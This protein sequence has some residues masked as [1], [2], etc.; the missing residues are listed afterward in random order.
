V[1]GRFIRRLQAHGDKILA[2]ERIDD[3]HFASGARDGGICIWDI[4]PSALVA[5]S[6][7]HSNSIMALAVTPQGAVSSSYDDLVLLWDL[8]GEARPR[9]LHENVGWAEWLIAVNPRRVADVSVSG[10]LRVWDL[11]PPTLVYEIDYGGRVLAMKR[12]VD[13]RFIVGAGG[14][15]HVWSAS[16]PRLLN[17]W[18]A[19]DDSI[20]HLATFGEETLVTASLDKTMRAWNLATGEEIASLETDAGLDVVA[21][22]RYAVFVSSLKDRRRAV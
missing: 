5:E 2:L 6:A 13:D 7:R 4:S 21:A 17:R 16:R 14:E 11:E 8:E 1:E 15:V 22:D 12:L 20:R 19:H 3:R 9:V 18:R 10:K